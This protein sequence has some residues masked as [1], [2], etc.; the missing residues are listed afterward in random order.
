M[1]TCGKVGSDVH[2]IIKEV[3]IRRVEYRSEIHSNKSQHRWRFSF[4]LQQALLFRLSAISRLSHLLF[5]VLPF[6]INQA[7]ANCDALVEWALAFII[8]GDGAAAAGQPTRRK[9]SSPRSYR[10][11]NHDLPRTRDPTAGPPAHLRRRSR[12][13]QQ[14]LHQRRSLNWSP[15]LGLGMCRLFIF[16]G[17]PSIP[18]PTTA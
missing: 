11:P 9:Y 8:A 17:R 12:T 6:I 18:S 13:Y 16:P 14:Q 15:R 3:A 7:A 10:V 5:T 4:V 1:S 2:A